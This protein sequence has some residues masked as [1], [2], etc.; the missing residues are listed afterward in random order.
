[1]LIV[2]DNGS[3]QDP[4]QAL[5]EQV[6]GTTVAR[7]ERN[8]GYGAACNAGARVALAAG[9][10]HILFLNND[11]TLQAGALK[12][13]ADAAERHPDAILAPKIVFSA[14]PD[15]VW[16]AG[17]FVVGPL[18]SNHHLGEGEPADRYTAERQVAWA[19]GCALFVSS[20]LFERLG[21][22]DEAYFL[23]LEDVDWCLRAAAHGIQTWLVP[24]SVVFHE[25]SL[26]MR[27]R[28]LPVRYYSY[29]NHYRLA[30]HHA[31]RWARPLA[32]ADAVWTLV[33]A[34]MRSATSASYRK[35]AYYH[36]RTRGVLDFLRG[37][38]GPMPEQSA[39]TPLPEVGDTHQA[40]LGGRT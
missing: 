11:T 7:L 1:M 6:P 19:T 16:S 22:M 10:E 27:S 13:L 17:G 24:E 15:I 4:A 14:R 20:K 30:A 33:K 40:G 31:A 28:K 37:R 35:D 21:P 2:A 34:G 26:V 23:Y 32:Y 12:A 3:D 18:C 29:R 25:V 39:S 8:S 5:E 36:A 9:A 38:F